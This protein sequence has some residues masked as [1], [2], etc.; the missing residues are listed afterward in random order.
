MNIKNIWK[1]VVL[2][3]EKH[4]DERGGIVDIF[5]DTPMSHITF[6]KSEPKAVRGNHYHKETTQHMLITK[7][8]LTYWYKPLASDEPAK[9]ILVRAGD[10]VTTPPNEIHALVIGDDGNEFIVFTEGLRGGKDYEK[11]TFRVETII[12]NSS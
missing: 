1:D 11:D 5:Y 12:G 6:I 9:Y 4:T 3:L 7:G 8:S 10:L 2:P